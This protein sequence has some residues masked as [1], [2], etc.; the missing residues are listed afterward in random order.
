MTGT[1]GEEVGGIQGNHCGWKAGK[2]TSERGARVVK[3]CEKFPG[4]DIK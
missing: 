2:L 1:K 4:K 3:I